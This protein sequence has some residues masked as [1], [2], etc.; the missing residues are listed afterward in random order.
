MAD[1]EYATKAEVTAVFKK[2]KRESD[3]KSCFDCSAK[4]PT[5]ASVG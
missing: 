5:W 1:T 3:N 2:T 4:N